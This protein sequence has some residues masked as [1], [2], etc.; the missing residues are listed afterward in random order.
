MGYYINTFTGDYPITF[1][2]LKERLPN[3]SFSKEPKEIQSYCRV[4]DGPTVE[5]D[6]YTQYVTEGKPYLLN[7][8][9]VRNWIVSDHSKIT[10]NQ[11]AERNLNAKKGA[12]RKKRNRLLAATDWA[13]LPDV[14]TSSD[15]LEYRQALR[16]VPKQSSFPW[17]ISWPELPNPT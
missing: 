16:E 13:V 2:E 12:V 5:F 6:G 4:E 7:G 14:H 8:V 3:V 15:M 17:E 11:N 1:S 9:Y 10:L